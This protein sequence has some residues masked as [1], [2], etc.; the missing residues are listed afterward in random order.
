MSLT[1]KFTNRIFRRISGLAWDLM[2]GQV[3]IKTPDG[4]YTLTKTETPATETSA[5][6]TSYGVGVNILEFDAAIPAFAMATPFDE[7]QPGDLIVGETKIIGWAVD[8]SAAALKVLDHNGFT[9]TYTPPKVS[10]AL[11]QGSTVMVVKNLFNL[12][13]GQDGA[14][15]FAANLLPLLVLGKGNADI[16]KLLPI[17]LMGGVGG[18]NSGAGLMSNPL[19]LLALT[20]GL[21]GSGGA[22]SPKMDKLLPLMMLGGMGGGAGAMS[23]PLVMMTLLGDT[24]VFG[25][26]GLFGGDDDAPAKTV[27]QTLAA[28]S[29]IRTR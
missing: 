9:K 5:A 23:N 7:V 10:I 22:G 16:E 1:S 25:G 18:S 21:G 4:L 17:M 6:S 28:P 20:G 14:N 24:D 8:K 2:S 27:P 29:L 26:L 3:G 13:G 11:T 19:A 12:T 15:S